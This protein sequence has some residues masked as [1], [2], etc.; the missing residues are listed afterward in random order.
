MIQKSHASQTVTW[1]PSSSHNHHLNHHLPPRHPHVTSP[2]QTSL[3]THKPRQPPNNHA[4]PSHAHV[5]SVND[6]KCALHVAHATSRHAI[7]TTSN[8]GHPKCINRPN[9][10]HARR[11]P[12]AANDGQPPTSNIDHLATTKTANNGCRTSRAHERQRQ[13]H[14]WPQGSTGER[15]QVAV[16]DTART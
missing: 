12:R 10:Y 9:D 1:L 8:P 15:A 7:L 6:N 13:V 16:S 11:R 5:T 3:A 4:R 2:P 14:P